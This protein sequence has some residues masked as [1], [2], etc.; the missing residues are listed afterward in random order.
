MTS[1]AIF[2]RER[3]QLA[4]AEAETASLDNVR[5]RCLRAEAAWTAM[6][7]RAERTQQLRDKREAAV[8]SRG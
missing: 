7:D 1:P 3:A 5:E 4:Q 6:A 2:Y 8:I